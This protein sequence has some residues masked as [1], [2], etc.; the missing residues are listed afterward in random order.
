MRELSTEVLIVGGG[1]GGT[2][3]ALSVS[4]LGRKVIYAIDYLGLC[5]GLPSG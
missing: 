1:L 3:A 4:R 2:A 5:R